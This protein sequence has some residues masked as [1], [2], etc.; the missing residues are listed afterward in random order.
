MDDKDFVKEQYVTLREEI[1]ERQ[2]RKF[3]IMTAGLFGVPALSFVGRYFEE[4]IDIGEAFLVI[5]PIIVI[6]TCFVYVSENNGV[7]RAGRYIRTVVEPQFPSIVG[8]EQW[9]ENH[10]D[11]GTRDVDKYVNFCV[12]TV[13]VLYYVGSIFLFHI[14][15]DPLF[16]YAVLNQIVIAT[17]I[18]LGAA[19]IYL[20]F[21]KARY[22]TK[23]PEK[24]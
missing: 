18:I 16:G 8:W 17:Y 2:T 4:K 5:A 1:G 13:S 7:M 21:V 6:V 10:E 14:Y 24:S 12:F 20:A 19:F 3:R 23:L 9:L 15:A 22:S 11:V